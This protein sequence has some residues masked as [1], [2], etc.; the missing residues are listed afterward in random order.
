MPPP[1]IE[2][3]PIVTTV[4]RVGPTDPLVVTLHNGPQGIPGEAGTPVSYVDAQDAATLAA[5][6]EYTDNAVAVGTVAGAG[7]TRTGDTLDVVA[8]A[9]GSIVVN[10][11]DVQVGVLAT[12]AQHGT[13]GGGTLHANV[14]AAGAAGFMTGADKTKLDGLPVSAQP[15][16]GELSAIA[17]LT[18][19]ADTVPYFTGS[20]TAALA[21]LTS[22]GRALLDD[23]TA[24]DQRTTL[25]LGTLATQNGTAANIPTTD[26]KAALVGTGT[27]SAANKYVTNDDTRLTNARTPTG[28]AGGG[29]TGT[30]PNPTVL[31]NAN[32][33][34]PVTSIG[35][36]T[37]IADAELAALAGLTSAADTLPYFTGSGTAALASFTGAGRALMDDA[38]AAAQRATLELGTLAT[39]SGTFS[40]TSSGTNTGDQTISLTGDVT[41]SGTG[42]FAATIAPA[43]VTLAKMAN[44]AQDTLIGR[45]TASTGVPETIPLTAAGRNLIDDATAGD[46]RTTLGLGTLATQSGTFSGTHAGA[47]S[48]TNTG[49]QTITLTGDVTGSGTGSFAATIANDSVS[50]AKMQEITTDRLIGRDTASTGNPEEISVGGGLEFTGSAGIQRSALTGDVTATAGSAATTIAN[51]AVTNAKAA[52]M[53]A[54]TFKGNNTGSTADPIDLTQAQLTADL[55][56]ATPALQGMMPAADKAKMGGLAILL[57]TTFGGF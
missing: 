40:G 34:G 26:E 56:A 51:D 30:Y 21:S 6:Q 45:S 27:P 49:D 53:G 37:T 16:D 47:S 33:T 38:D 25:E 23:A 20:G 41:G 29:L 1:V 13:R 3:A 24:S 5:A 7:L 10:A 54:H 15:L 18:S 35:N 9:D 31:T 42:S 55:N 50:F 39:Q 32:L 19:A 28:A 43:A 44:L 12:D 36:A 11:N 14:V 4:I 46:Q 52:N 8:N 48:G 2:I 22:A 17:G 57:Q